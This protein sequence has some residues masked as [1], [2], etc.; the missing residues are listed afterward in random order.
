MMRRTD[1][2]AQGNEKRFFDWMC[3]TYAQVEAKGKTI[4]DARTKAWQVGLK[5]CTSSPNPFGGRH[6]RACWVAPDMR[7]NYP[8]H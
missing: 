8:A 1:F 2:R 3:P 6:C 4:V 5:S 7:I